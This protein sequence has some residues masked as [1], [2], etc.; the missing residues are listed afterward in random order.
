MKKLLQSLLLLALC[1]TASAQ[2]IPDDPAFRVG[3]LEN[4]LTYYLYHNE[5]PAGVAEF[6][7]IHNVGALQEEDNQDGLAHFLE[8][9]A[10]N[11]TRHYPGKEL[12]NFLA[13]DGVRFGYN[14]NAYTGRH[15]TVYNVSAVPLARESFVDSVLMILHDWSCDISCEQAD[16]DA[17]RGVISEEWRLRDEPRYR[18]MC[19][20]T[21]LVYKGAKHPRRTVI[22]SYDVINGFKRNEILDFYHKWYRPDLQAIAIVGDID[23]DQMEAR[24]RAKFA[25]IPAAVNPAPKDPCIPPAQPEPMFADQTDHQIR[26]QAVKLIYKNRFPDAETRHREEYIRDFFCR[27]IVSSVLSDRFREATRQEGSPAKSIV[28]VAASN[29]PDFNLLMCTITPREKTQLAGATQVALREVNRLLQHGISNEEFEV[30]RLNVCQRYHLNRERNREEIR[31]GD[32]VKVVIENFLRNYPLLNPVDEDALERRIL[33]SITPEEAAAYP[34]KMIA[35][36]E[37]IYSNCY[38]IVDDPEVPIPEADFRAMVASAAETPLEPAFISYPKL[39]LN[40]ALEA[41]GIVSEKK[42]AKGNRIWTLSNGIKVHYRQSEPYKSATRLALTLRYPTGYGVFDEASVTADRYAANYIARSLSFRKIDKASQRNYP[43]LLGVSL[44]AHLTSEAA[45]LSL[46]TGEERAENGFKALCLQLTDPWFGTPAQ[47]NKYKKNSLEGFAKPKRDRDRFDDHFREALY[48]DNPWSAKADSAA[49]NAVTPERL[50]TVFDRSF[51][52][53]P[54]LWLCSDLDPAQ[55]RAWVERYI[56][57]LPVGEPAPQG[58]LHPLREGFT[59]RVELSESYPPVSA[60]LTDI[61]CQF[62]TPARKDTKGRMVYA[63]LDY[64]MSDRYVALIREERGG[65]YHVGFSTELYDDPDRDAVSTVAFQTRPELEE[66]LVKDVEEELAR[67]AADGPTE[68]EMEAARKYLVKHEVEMRP[69]IAASAGIQLSQLE[70]YGRYGIDYG[71]DYA[72]VVKSV[73]AKD[74]RRLAR[75]IG[76]NGKLFAIYTEK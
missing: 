63:F 59:G 55:V 15:E 45:E 19:R 54:E 66:I 61:S 75:Q 38:N 4:G 46:S 36:A 9:M 32:L 49:V 30:A 34:A 6:Y 44:Q 50:R 8:H 22:G 53:T 27:Q 2:Y 5:N 42:D 60:P 13:K 23:L 24:V 33:F 68:A 25:D 1:A 74:V 28:A 14:V 64:I 40:Y 18:M 43:E 57:A 71:Y 26:Y 70:R 29:S 17:E 10:F 73:K 67:M 62:R 31:S 3:R 76:V 20:Q 11:G 48:P 56:A 21:E 41:G 7:I 16:L 69:R 37:A 47:L 12:L 39:D 72:R 35:D 52:G 58:T 51:S 65:A